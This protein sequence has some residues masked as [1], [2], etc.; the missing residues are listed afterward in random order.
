[1]KRRTF[2]GLAAGAAALPTVSRIARAQTYPSRPISMIVPFPPG[3]P[4]DVIGRLIAERM[5]TMLGQPIIVENAAGANGSIG[6]G[7]VVRASNDGYTLSI[8]QV[9]T[10]VFNGATYPLQYDLLNDLEPISLLTDSRYLVVA[11]KAMPADD[12]LGLISWLKANSQKASAATAGVGS[13]AHVSGILFQ[14]ITDTQFQFVPYRGGAP[15]VQSVVAGETDFMIADLVSSLPQVRAGNIKA[16][17]VAGPSRLPAAPAIPTVDEA[18]AHGL[19]T[20]FWHGLWAPKGTS[21]DI[22]AKLNGAVVDALA[23]TTVRSRLSDLGQE[24]FP[25]DQQTPEG[26][27]T[28]QKAEIEKWWPII[29]A[30]NIKPE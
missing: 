19:Y 30:A 26:L 6:I 20:S 23:D 28:L 29:K 12:L 22:I 27:R 16:Y 21:K 13:L 1:M 9:G 5:R 14:R 24:T 10:H 11:K 25:R 2:L 4:T 18:G 17:A 3:G 7:R 8:G 15:A